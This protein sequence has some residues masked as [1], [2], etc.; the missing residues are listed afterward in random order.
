MY[1]FRTPWLFKYFFNKIVWS[2]K[3]EDKNIYLT[4]DDG[5]IPS[6]TSWVLKTLKEYNAKATF[7]CVGENV[8]KYPEVF[9][10]VLDEGHMVGNH[11][12]H[13]I[14]GMKHKSEAYLDDIALADEYI[15]SNLFRPPYGKFSYKQYKELSKTYQIVMWDV[16]SGDFDKGIDYKTCLKKLQNNI[17]PGSVIVFHDSVKS[18]GIL[19]LVLPQILEEYTTKGFTFKALEG[20]VRKEYHKEIQQ[21]ENI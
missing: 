4:F 1:F 18:E 17:R 13:H 7:F 14:N 9:Q 6:V 15:K 8:K 12:F 20:V 19:R 10:N 2:I 21:Q 16:L 3:G 5:P 11:T